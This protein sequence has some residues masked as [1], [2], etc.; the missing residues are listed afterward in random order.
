MSML[1]RLTT[2]A[3]ISA[4]LATAPRAQNDESRGLLAGAAT[5]LLVDGGAGG[6]S[7][8]DTLV[9]PN[10]FSQAAPLTF[11]ASNIGAPSLASVF[12]FHGN[13]A[14]IDVDAFSTGRD[15]LLIDTLGELSV[16]PLSW[17]VWSFSL[18]VGAVGKVGSRIEAEAQNGAV[19]AALFS[20]VLPGSNLPPEVVD[21]TERSHSRKDLGVGNGPNTEVDGLDFPLIL[22]RDQQLN[23]GGPGVAIEP[24][25]A[26][27]LSI[28][29]TIYFSVTDASK[30]NVPA[31]WWTTLGGVTTAPSGASILCCFRSAFGSPWTAPRVYLPYYELGL[32]VHE[33]LDALALDTVRDNVVYS[34][35]GTLRDQFLFYYFGTDDGGAPPATPV[36]S[37]G[38]NVSDKVGKASIDD[39]D[40]ICT[41]DPVIGS[42]GTPPPGGDDFGSSCGAPQ[43]GLLGVPEISGS[44]YRRYENGT[45][46]VDTFLVGWPPIAGR[47][48]G[49]AA[50]FLTIGNSIQ[51]LPIGGIQVRDPSNQIAGDPRT[52]T[53][54]LPATIALSNFDCTCRWVALDFVTAEIAEA[55]PVR[56]FL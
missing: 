18:R 36:T 30:H 37:N 48:P 14:G 4:A 20:Y 45:T 24:G 6:A 7:D 34:V 3:A 46:Y 53:F 8:S 10:G 23:A 35:E 13:P 56:M 19:G 1:A 47:A 9:H 40:A 38:Q 50:A 33:D 26:P 29:E 54:V 51:L 49:F 31:A 2:C 22:G 52:A 11:A 28:P 16:P 55:W 12:A 15:D 27:L 41:L 32:G 42:I 17:S 39:V 25:F 5:T 43:P 21:V 44:A